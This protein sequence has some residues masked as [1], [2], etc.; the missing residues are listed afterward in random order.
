MTNIGFVTIGSFSFLLFVHFWFQGWGLGIVLVVIVLSS[1]VCLSVL[2][3]RG[4]CFFFV[5]FVLHLFVCL[6]VCLFFNL[7]YE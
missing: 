2:I 4:N 5:L 7:I 1:S 6:F 3:D